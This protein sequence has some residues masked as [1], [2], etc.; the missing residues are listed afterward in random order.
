MV[1]WVRSANDT[2]AQCWKADIAHFMI[3][4]R[5][6]PCHYLITKIESYG[7]KQKKRKFSGT[8]KIHWS[9]SRLPRIL[10]GGFRGVRFV[11]KRTGIFWQSLRS[12]LEAQWRSEETEERDEIYDRIRT[13]ERGRIWKQTRPFFQRLWTR[14]LYCGTLSTPVTQRASLIH[15]G[16]F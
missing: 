7:S 16:T 14:H 9:A 13:T 5:Q 1:K 6:R 2:I 3:C 11:K 10:P 8:W 15:P 4:G 12:G